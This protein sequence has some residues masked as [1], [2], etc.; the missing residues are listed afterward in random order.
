MIIV[1]NVATGQSEK[2]F[3]PLD[4]RVYVL[5]DIDCQSD[6][7]MERH[8]KRN[9]VENI[10]TEETPKMLDFS[11]NVETNPGRKTN[12]KGTPIV[13]NAEKI[14]LSFLLN[15]LDGVLENPGR[16][17][18]MTSNFPKLLDHALIRPG[19]IDVIADFKKCFS[20]TLI[21]MIEFFYDIFLTEDEKNEIMLLREHIISPAEMGKLMFE[22]FD[23][24]ENVLVKLRELSFEQIE[25]DE[26]YVLSQASQRVIN[27]ISKQIENINHGLQ[28]CLTSDPPLQN[29]ATDT[30]F[31]PHKKVYEEIKLADSLNA[32]KSLEEKIASRLNNDDFYHST[33]F[34]KDYPKSHS[35]RE[36]FFNKSEKLA[37]PI[38]GEKH[39]HHIS[40][41][42]G[43]EEVEKI[44]QK[45]RD[46][47]PK[48][49][50]FNDAVPWQ[51]SSFSAF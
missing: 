44:V 13:N 31:Y 2:Y 23:D 21:E 49:E 37:E 43:K 34:A 35:D 16:I 8:L 24:Y 25:K 20:A 10:D 18:I 51:S 48:P 30:I 29:G 1:L 45:S 39:E 46:D 40:S 4:Q 9:G 38:A 36:A 32:E 19:R 28:D 22:N 41:Y 27:E 17:I 6:L 12:E 7:V 33:S 14:D 3:I 5:E 42:I 26:I 47:T 50:E 15:L 11:V